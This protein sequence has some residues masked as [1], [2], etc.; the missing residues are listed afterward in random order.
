MKLI[1]EDPTPEFHEQLLSLLADHAAY[2]EIQTD[3]TWTPDRAS[4]YWNSLPPRAQ[5][6]LREAVLHNGFVSADLLREDGK[7]L[8]GH[9]GPL[10]SA[11]ERG[12]RKGWW[13]DGM[14]SPIQPQGPGFGQVVGYRI[15]DD[16]IEV[17][18]EA[19]VDT[20]HQSALAEVID[21]EGGTW[22]PARAI[23]A[24]RREGH[25]VDAKRARAV[26]RR[27]AATGLIV[28]TDGTAAIYRRT[29]EQ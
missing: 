8:R 22:D 20:T 2:V 18:E 14:R 26:L 9:S 23:Q 3:A 12:F 13:P 29:N 28:K 1:I 21:S 16:L 17:F 27:I 10:N 7:S 4:L 5:R 11:L 25:I 6:I 15:P 24:L 19:I